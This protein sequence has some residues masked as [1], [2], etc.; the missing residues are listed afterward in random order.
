MRKRRLKGGVKAARVC[1][2][3]IKITPVLASMFVTAGC[4]NGYYDSAWPV[5]ETEVFSTVEYFKPSSFDD[6]P[7]QYPQP[8][9]VN[10]PVNIGFPVGVCVKVRGRQLNAEISAAE[11]GSAESNYR[12]IQRTSDPKQCIPDADRPYFHSGK[13]GAWAA[14]LDY[15]WTPDSCISISTETV[16]RTDCDNESVQPKFKPI[17]VITGVADMSSCHS[18][19][20]THPTRRFT[21][22]TQVQK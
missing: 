5:A 13:D 4:S 18:G 9:Q 12:I 7:G 6:I 21:I 8:Q 2:P 19:G 17:L 11:C 3:G 16:I 15:A 22:C 1:V 20:Y 14:C 10:S